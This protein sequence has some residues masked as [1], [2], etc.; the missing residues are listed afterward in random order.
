MRKKRYPCM[1]CE[2]L[3]AEIEQAEVCEREH[4]NPR[5]K[6]DDDGREYADPSDAKADRL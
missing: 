1:L 6:G 3:Y 4:E 5:E 2:K